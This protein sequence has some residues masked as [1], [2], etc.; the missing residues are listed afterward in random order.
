M[1]RGEEA[2]RERAEMMT[3]SKWGENYDAG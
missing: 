3:E 2:R 1:G